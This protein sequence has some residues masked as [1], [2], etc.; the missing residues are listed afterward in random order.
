MKRINIPKIPRRIDV[1]EIPGLFEE[2]SSSWYEKRLLLT[3][4]ES[5][6][7]EL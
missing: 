2:L 4:R 1:N 3:D 5:L 7:E 6:F